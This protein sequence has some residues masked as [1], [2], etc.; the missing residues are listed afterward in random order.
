MTYSLVIN[1]QVSK[2]CFVPVFNGDDSAGLTA[3]TDMTRNVDKRKATFFS[4]ASRRVYVFGTDV[5]AISGRATD[6]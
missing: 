1:P 5:Q 6:P 2:L 4:M 3:G